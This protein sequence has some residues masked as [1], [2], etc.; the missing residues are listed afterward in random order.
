VVTI[1]TTKDLGPIYFHRL[2]YPVKPRGLMERAY[3]QEID[4]E[5]RRGYGTSVRLPFTKQALVIG[6]WKKTGY[7]ESQALTYAI[8]GRGLKADDPSWETIRSGEI[9]CLDET[10]M[11]E[12]SQE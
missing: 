10:E 4:G 12:L 8:N 11:N 1:A 2:T 3:S 6:V 7:T 9:E 5:F